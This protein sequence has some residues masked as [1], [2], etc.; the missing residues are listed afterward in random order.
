M[1]EVKSWDWNKVSLG[2]QVQACGSEV[3]EL[4]LG[5]TS[6]ENIAGHLDSVMQCNGSS[7]SYC[8][9][10][11]ELQPDIALFPGSSEILSDRQ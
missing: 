3:R 2:E 10:L 5:H 11:N 9:I 7:R 4:Q 1:E 8:G 6:R